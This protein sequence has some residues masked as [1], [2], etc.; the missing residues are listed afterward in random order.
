MEE[1][2]RQRLGKRVTVSTGAMTASDSVRQQVGQQLQERAEVF[3]QLS[4]QLEGQLK[5][6]P[7]EYAG[8][9]FDRTAERVCKGCALRQMCWKR[10]YR[11]TYQALNGALKRME[12]RGFCREKDFQEPFYGRCM[13]LRAF[14]NT[15]NEELYA[16]RNRRRFRVRLMQSKA[17]FCK[18]FRQTSRL[19]QET[20]AELGG[21]WMADSN[22]IAAVKRVLRSSGINAAVAVQRSSQGRRVIEL[23]GQELSQ[24]AAAEGRRR[25]SHAVGI[26]LETGELTR[27]AQGQRLRFRESPRL[28]ARV[29]AAAR[30]RDGESVSGDNGSWF[31]DSKGCL[32]VVLCDGMGAGSGAAAESR[33]V[34]RLLESFLKSGVTAETA[35]NTLAGALTM[36]TDSGFR[37]STIDLLQVDL[38]SGEGAVYKMGA[39]PSYFRHSGIVSRITTSALPAGLSLEPEG[40]IALT[41]F[42]VT[43][44]DLLVLVTD[45]VSDG[46][47]DGWIQEKAAQFSG[48]SPRELALALLEDKHSRRDDDRTAVVILLGC[49]EERDWTAPT[50]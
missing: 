35:L 6:E 19:L 30:P 38:F 40:Q 12:E 7:A 21:E 4:Q 34:L 27:T 25:L 14:V 29:G 16:W 28:A 46:D 36:R 31:K 10:D 48:E 50:A 24:L 22:G 41:R 43:P 45:G 23:T 17:L 2:I 11:A 39:A 13:R 3:R 18:Q 49:R 37:F 33:L 1:R 15:A 5:E 44:G 8:A 9:V 32:W 20:A 42:Q 26:P 47:E